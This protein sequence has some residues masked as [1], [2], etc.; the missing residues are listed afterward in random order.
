VAHQLLEQFRPP[1]NVSSCVTSPPAPFEREDFLADFSYEETLSN[2][3]FT[4]AQFAILAAQMPASSSNE[5]QVFT[6]EFVALATLLSLPR[7]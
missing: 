6:P 2:L 3:P 1:E 7:I 5:P 4:E